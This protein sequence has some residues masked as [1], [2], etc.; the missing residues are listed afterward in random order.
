MRPL[1]IIIHKFDR[2]NE[3]S[4]YRNI[5]RG[6][7]RDERHLITRKETENSSIR[8][9]RHRRVSR[10]HTFLQILLRIPSRLPT[11]P[12]KINPLRKLPCLNPTKK[13]PRLHKHNP[14]FPTNR[15][16]FEHHRINHG[17]I[18]DGKHGDKSRENRPEKKLVSPD[19]TDPLC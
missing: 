18:N 10:K 3:E 6:N 9:H 19:I 11:G 12:P 1:H 8:A 16:M 2:R 5:Y 13:H 4:T 7:E 17:N 14:P 15:R